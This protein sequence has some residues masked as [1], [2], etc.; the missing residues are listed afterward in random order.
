MTGASRSKKN[1]ENRRGAD[2]CA[3]LGT[4]TMEMVAESSLSFA[5]LEGL[6]G[7]IPTQ[8]QV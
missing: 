3:A 6:L 7:Y 8:H 4:V 5:G 1:V 2:L